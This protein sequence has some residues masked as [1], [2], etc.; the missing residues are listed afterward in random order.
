M[1]FRSQ[2]YAAAYLAWI[3]AVLARCDSTDALV[4][5][6]A[7]EELRCALTI[8]SVGLVLE[9][10]QGRR[11]DALLDRKTSCRERV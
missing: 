6:Q 8:D 11:R 10:Y 2:N 3:D 7:F 4:V 9:D 1:L 5:R